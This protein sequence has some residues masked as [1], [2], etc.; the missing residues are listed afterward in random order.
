MNTWEVYI[1]IDVTHP[2]RTGPTINVQRYNNQNPVL[3]FQLFNTNVPVMLDDT[4]TVSIAFTNTNNES[5]SGLGNLQVVNPYRGTISYELVSSDLTMS[6]LITVTLGVTT[7]T[8]FFTLQCSILVHTI[9]E[10]L[11]KALN[12]N[13]YMLGGNLMASNSVAKICILQRGTYNARKLNGTL[14]ETTVYFV[15]ENTNDAATCMSLYIGAARETDLINVRD[16]LDSQGVEQFLN[17]EL[18]A[19]DIPTTF[20]CRDKLY[21]F[22][23]TITNQAELYM[24]GPEVGAFI[25]AGSN[26]IFWETL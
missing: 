12:N 17:H 1:P 14:N 4:T 25:P 16:L 21:Y 22:E 23:N 7:A 9:N 26:T 3:F 10:D 13:D 19:G 20:K 5:V 8:S 18:T 11:L 6:G 15:K 2:I 24:W